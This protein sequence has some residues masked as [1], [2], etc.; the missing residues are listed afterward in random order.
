MSFVCT[1]E[2]VSGRM[3]LSWDELSVQNRFER[4]TK[5]DLSR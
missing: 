5:I 4:L 3:S 1:V 2:S